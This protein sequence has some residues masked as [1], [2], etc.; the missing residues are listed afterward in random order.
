V[1][2]PKQELIV[3]EKKEERRVPEIA[4]G[5][6]KP[7]LLRRDGSARSL[8]MAFLSELER[9]YETKGV[10]IFDYVY[11]HHPLEYFK[12]LVA[13]SKV[14]RI[15]ADVQHTDM[16]KPQTVDEI[17]Q[18]VE[19]K[20]GTRGRALFEKYLAAIKPLRGADDE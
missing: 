13:L 10:A 7:M 17:L 2:K 11:E 15:E 14:V 8:S 20:T 12:A 18:R 1:K 6:A 19:E 4:I 9:H 5:G 16:R 3:P